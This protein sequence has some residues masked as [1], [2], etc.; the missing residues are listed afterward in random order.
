MT[1]LP[2]APSTAPV[3]SRRWLRAVAGA[4]LLSIVLIWAAFL[5][6][7]PSEDLP[8]IA[9]VPLALPLWGPYLLVLGHLR[10]GKRKK[11]L[12][13]AVALGSTAFVMAAFLLPE[14]ADDV[15]TRACL[16][17][18]GLMQAALVASAIKAYQ[19]LG[20]EAGD[21]RTLAVRLLLLLP[22]LAFSVAIATRVPPEM[23]AGRAS[24]TSNL[25]TI[26]TAA[27]TYCSTYENGYPASLAVLGAPDTGAPDCWKADL[28]DPVLAGTAT[29][30]VSPS[31]S[32][33]GNAFLKVGYIFEYKPGPAVGKPVPGCPPGVKSYTFTGRPLKYVREGRWGERSYFTDETGIIRGT[34]ENRAA[35]ASDPP[36]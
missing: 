21:T 4:G 29:P 28:V 9:T 8:G 18:F 20:W 36:I 3:A 24:V 32:P 31:A 33:P 19:T 35:T 25:R 27:V 5:A 10:W 34:R 30:T 17:L 7:S 16:E 2:Q 13:W 6:S 22:F 11:A 1:S 23:R 14:V 12:A 15:G 26:N